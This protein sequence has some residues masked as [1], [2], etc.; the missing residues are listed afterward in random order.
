MSTP[1]LWDKITAYVAKNKLNTA[2]EV[3]NLRKEVIETLVG[4]ASDDLVYEQRLDCIYDDEPLGFEED[5]L[6]SATK[7]R[8]QDPLEEVDLGDG[9]IK[10]TTYISAR[11][12]KEFRDRGLELLKEHKDCFAWD[13]NEIS[14]LSREMVELK[15]PI[16]PDKK[17]VKHIPRRFAPQILSKI[18]E[19]I[20]RLLKSKFI[21]TARYVDWLANIVPVKK[22]NGTIRVCIDFRDL[23][24]AT[25][26]DEYPMPVAEILVDSAAG[27]E[28]LS[29]LDGYSGYNQIFIVE[30][31]V[32]K[33]A[34]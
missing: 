10:M 2:K 22:K 21:K 11:I 33:T 26:K 18:K 3:D 28:Y 24:L 1:N 15:L 30:E 5:P 20:E 29:M 8:A 17:P 34:F 16:R 7:M 27:F 4:D 31:D 32:S 19:E 6:G 13:Y 25:P 12:T 23:N 14:G 9:P